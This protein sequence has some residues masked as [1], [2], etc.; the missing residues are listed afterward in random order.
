MSLQRSQQSA[1]AAA[2]AAVEDFLPDKISCFHVGAGQDLL[3]ESM[4]ARCTA[5]DWYCPEQ[6]I[7]NGS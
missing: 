1:L 6:T 2:V 4:V 5:S 3:L 7:T